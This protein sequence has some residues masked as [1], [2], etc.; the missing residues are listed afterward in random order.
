[1]ASPRPGIGARAVAGTEANMDRIEQAART[2]AYLAVV[3]GIALH[4]AL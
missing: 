1:M 2:L 4:F 3:V